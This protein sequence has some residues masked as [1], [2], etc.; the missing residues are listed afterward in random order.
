ML[1]AIRNNAQGVF[2]WIVVGLIVVSFALFG[3]G[4]YLSGASKVVV[5]SINGTEISGTALTR[6]YQNYQE[7][8]RKMFGEQ[9]NPEMFGT[10]RV[11]R[12][13]LQGLITQEVMNQMLHEQGYLASSEQVFEKIKKYEAFQEDGVFSAKRYKEVLSLQGMNGEAFENDLSRDIASQQIRGAI[14]SSAFLTEKEKKTLATLQNQKRDIGYFDISAKPYR[15]LVNVSDEDIKSYYEQN[16]QLYLTTEKVQL[17]YI[18]I[19]MDDVAAQQEV[20]D[21]MVKQHYESSAENYMASDDAG[22]KK[23]ITDLRKQIQQGADFAT[24]AKKHSQDKGSAKQGGDLGYVT[25]G[26]EEKFDNV[27]FALKK[28][29]VSQVIKSKQGFQIIQLNDIRAGDPEERKVRHILIKAERKLKPLADV[30]VAIKKELQYQLAGKVFFDDADQMN[31]LSYESPDSLEPV[32]DA[33][34]LKVKTS[35]L[36]T[37]RGGTGLFANPK[38]LTAAF[39]NEVLKEGRNS[40]LLE[41]S[42]TQLVVL[43]IKQHLPA[44]VQALDKVK[45]QIKNSLLQEQASKKVQDVT[46]D[47]LARL[48]SN[49]TIDSVKQL[50]P[51]VKWTKPGWIQR[52]A[53]TENKLP[54][55]LRQ[56][57]FA[58]PKPVDSATSWDKIRLQSGS[59]AVVALFNVKDDEDARPDDVRIIEVMGNAAYDSFVQHLKSQADVSISQA[60]IDTETEAN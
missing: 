42:D 47:I 49:E 57:A 31:N 44:S 52:K 18:E 39:S 20:T 3:L 15:K 41:L 34:G 30:E 38:I 60:A 21:K 59:Q 6:A 9:Y 46:T 40:E 4:S 35:T 13:V 53:E 51:E 7:R 12:E 36:M 50:Y 55:Q 43:R 32:A 5:A 24:L 16:S 19:N 45:S 2:V 28:N 26:I 25:R 29:E 58:M 33:L 11:K 37:R 56:H 14:T 8:L 27:V 10:A 1:Q 23:K 54:E 17:E 22:A 48:E